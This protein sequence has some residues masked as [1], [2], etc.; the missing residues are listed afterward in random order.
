MKWAIVSV[1][2]CAF[3]LDVAAANFDCEDS[4]VVES[5]KSKI[6][7]EAIYQ[8]CSYFGLPN[9]Y[10]QIEKLSR[11]TIIENFNRS[12]AAAVSRE[13]QHSKPHYKRAAERA[14]ELAR[15]A[16]LNIP[17]LL[18]R[19]QSLAE[20]Y[21]PRISKFT[22]RL[23]FEY[24]RDKLRSLVQFSLFKSSLKRMDALALLAADNGYEAFSRAINAIWLEHNAEQK[25]ANYGVRQ[26]LFTVQP[27]S[28]AP[29]MVDLIEFEP[30]VHFFR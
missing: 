1:I 13:T 24:D 9:D 18:I 15:D 7:C 5:V 2:L 27:S 28:K 23:K 30:P 17:G 19:V 20:D 29:Y 8:P 3:T 21:N 14:V 16:I 26:A 4:D 25:I 12:Y 22:C 11:Q 10:S 6:V